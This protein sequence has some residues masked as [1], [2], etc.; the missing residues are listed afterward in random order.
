M[1]TH[2]GFPDLVGSKEAARDGTPKYLLAMQ[3]PFPSPVPTWHNE[4]Y[5]AIAPERPELDCTGKTVIITGAGGCIGQETALAF[6]AANAKCLVLIGR[7]AS[8]LTQTKDA[9]QASSNSVHCSICCADVCDEKTMRQTAADV[10]TWDVLILNA[11]H[12]PKPAAVAT[13][14]I[15]DYWQAFETNVKSV[16]IATQ[17]FFPTA[18]T[19]RAAVLGVT[20]GA[21]ALTPQLT[22][23][24][25]GYMAS[26]TAMIKILE[27]LAVENPTMFVAGVHPGMVDTTIFRKSGSTPDQ[28]PMD[29][30]AL[31]AHFM[32]WLACAQPDFLQGKL[33]W[34]NWN[35]E[36]LKAAASNIQG[37]SQMTITVGGWPFTNIE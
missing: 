23:G 22:V 18:N 8:T 15:S 6:A 16:I 32:L 1:A 11:G 36:E 29:S 20:S 12:I 24:H 13:A 2:E 9:V 27:F 17:A 5:A 4:T 28:L 35:V 19:T 14:E 26:K 30:A 7:T 33:V 3:P 21:V 25:S 37:S 10:G 31:P 34:A